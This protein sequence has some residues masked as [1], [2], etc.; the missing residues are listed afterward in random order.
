M[1]YRNTIKRGIVRGFM[2]FIFYSFG[3]NDALFN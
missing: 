3:L 1:G 2:T